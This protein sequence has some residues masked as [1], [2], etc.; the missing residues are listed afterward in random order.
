MNLNDKRLHV[1]FVKFLGSGFY[2]F[3]KT[4]QSNSLA[5]NM[6]AYVILRVII[7]NHQKMHPLVPS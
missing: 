6:L 3:H 1:R 4:D 5:L 7:N 2:Y